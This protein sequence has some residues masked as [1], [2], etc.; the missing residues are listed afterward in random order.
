MYGVL[1][2]PFSDDK[3]EDKF[4][5]ADSGAGAVYFVVSSSE[6]SMATVAKALVSDVARL[7]RLARVEASSAADFARRIE[8]SASMIGDLPGESVPRK[9]ESIVE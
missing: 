6:A 8:I 3:E 5:V 1:I 9:G 7:I 2:F 4:S